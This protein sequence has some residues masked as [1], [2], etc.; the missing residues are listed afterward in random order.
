MFP[1]NPSVAAAGMNAKFFSHKVAKSSRIQVTSTPI[2]R[3]ACNPL[4]FQVTYV[5]ISTK[6]F[7]NNI[8]K[9]IKTDV[10][11][12]VKQWCPGFLLSPLLHPPKW[13]VA[14]KMWIFDFS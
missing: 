1:Q 4:S 13:D 10:N 11:Y 2:T 5:R 6:I 14:R 8:C 9:Y 3:Q 7:K 12:Y